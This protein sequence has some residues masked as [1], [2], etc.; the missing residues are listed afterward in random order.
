MFTRSPTIAIVAG[1][2]VRLPITDTATTPIVPTAIEVNRLIPSV[3]RPPSEITTAM[4]EKNTA[5][6]A[7]LLDVSIAWWT[8]APRCRSDR[9]RVTMN[10]E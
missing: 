3:S 4:P 1:R 10:S 2:N 7:V 9:N 5:R 8:V 6:P